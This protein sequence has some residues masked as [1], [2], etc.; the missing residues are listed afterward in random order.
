MRDRVRLAGLLTT[1]TPVATPS[2]KQTPPAPPASPQHGQ[3]PTAKTPPPKAST[4]A[5]PKKNASPANSPKRSPV[6]TGKRSASTTTQYAGPSNDPSFASDLGEWSR[7]I[8]G[9]GGRLVATQANGEEPVL[10]LTNLHG[11]VSETARAS[12]T[13]TEPASK[14]ETTEWGVP[15]TSLPP[16]V[17][18]P[19]KAP[20]ASPAKIAPAASP[21][22]A[23]HTYRKPAQC[24][25]HPKTYHPE[26]PPT[27]TQHTSATRIIRL[28]ASSLPGPRQNKSLIANKKYENAK[29]QHTRLA[30]VRGKSHIVNQTQNTVSTSMGAKW[31]QRCGPTMVAD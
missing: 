15:T 28:L 10:Q 20:V 11:N 13:A 24:Y 8:A 1:P 23:S 21:K 25:N 2:T 6:A 19:T 7:N 27:T 18:T 26:Y 16:T 4:L 12:E 31:A 17:S 22:T 5:S 29:K 14:A 9:L 30:Y 3:S